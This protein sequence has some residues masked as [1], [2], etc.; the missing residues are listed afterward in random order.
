MFLVFLEILLLRDFLVRLL[1][2]VYLHHC[3]TWPIFPSM[4]MQLFAP[5][6]SSNFLSPFFPLRIFSLCTLSTALCSCLL[7]PLDSFR[8][9]EWNAGD[10]R[11][12][13]T[14]LQHSPDTSH[15][16]GDVVVI[17]FVR[18]GLSFSELSTSFL[19]SLDPILII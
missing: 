5:P 9:H 14:E 16:S 1:Q 13:S 19:S 11:A 3:V 6:S 17:I 18:L 15:A 2:L 10:L 7:F 12:R 8:V 4:L